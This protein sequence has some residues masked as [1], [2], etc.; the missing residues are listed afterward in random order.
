MSYQYD[1]FISYARNVNK[2][3]FIDEFVERLENS[4]EFEE[5]LGRKPRVFFDKEGT[6]R[7]DGWEARLRPGVEG[8]RF[9]LVFLSPNYFFGENCAQEFEW[10]ISR[11]MRYSVFGKGAALMHVV[12]V[13]ALA[14]ADKELAYPEKMEDRIP[15][16]VAELRRRLGSASFD[17]KTRNRKKIDNALAGLCRYTRDNIWRQESSATAP[18]NDSYPDDAETFVGRHDDLHTLREN[19]ESR[20][21]AA[22]YGL[23]GIGKTELALAYGRAFGWDYQ[24][25][26][27]FIDCNAQK[28]LVG[29]TLGSGLDLMTDVKLQ[30]GEIERLETLFDTLNRRRE[31]IIKENVENERPENWGTRLLL[32]LDNVTDLELL[33]QEKLD[34]LP[35]F[36]HL[37]A[38]TRAKPSDFAPV[39]GQPVDSLIDSDA[40]E[41]LDALR[42]FGNKREQDAAAT[43]VKYLGGH[44]FRVE[45]IGEYLRDVKSE[46]YREF[47][48]KIQEKP[49]SLHK[50]I[51]SKEFQLC[52]QGTDDEEL[53]LPTLDRLT[54][55]AKT[56]L[57]W[58]AFF[59]PNSVAVPWLGE[60]A[61]LDGDD[62][63]A[64]LQELEEYR[65][66]VPVT[67]DL[68][69]G[70][71]GTFQRKTEDELETPLQLVNAKMARIHPVVREM[72][73]ER[74]PD[75][76]RLAAVEQISEKADNFLSQ[77]ESFEGSRKFA[78][79]GLDS[80][81]GFYYD[82]YLAAKKAEPSEKDLALI[83]TLYLIRIKVAYLR[84]G[85]DQ[86]FYEAAFELS[87][88]WA[89]AEPENLDAQ[90]NLSDAYHYLGTRFSCGFK[91]KRAIKEHKKGLAIR[92]KILERKPDDIEALLNLCDSYD[93]LAAEE[94]NLCNV[95]QEKE[96]YEKGL[97]I[98][99]KILAQEPDNPKAL[100]RLYATYFNLAYTPRCKENYG[101]AR[102]Y[103]N[104]YC[105]LLGVQCPL[106]STQS[107]FC[108]PP[109]AP[110]P[111]F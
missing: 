4:P 67:G 57:D 64:G 84:Y 96:Y 79:W 29:A 89:K 32:I 39:C 54:P 23:G 59:G 43:I 106:C 74:T 42:P 13:P 30:G 70:C 85:P 24:L 99:E 94:L 100:Y 51:D 68:L 82:R 19:L 95:K 62:L 14:N 86:K 1:Y 75:A 71:L 47:L 44:A 26:R 48:T 52:Y 80:A 25:G 98:L 109:R 58:A 104:S 72:I 31:E 83:K 63:R 41:L 27:V 105:N 12:N 61:K 38:T 8:A 69:K 5:L 108:A 35:E 107:R 66:L 103:Y 53:L 73:V 88:R 7:T 78:R 6:L 3:G 22:L 16:W 46:P 15:R 11:E 77:D 92:E 60:L 40:L 81:A 55:N 10:W 45:K 76:S 9:M 90:E 34:R 21:S 2:G 18:R 20:Q 101:E 28:S 111:S 17:L 91:F 50:M 37:V 97:E 93:Q 65:L 110:F 36:V 33:D 102:E 87:Q 49:G 56:L